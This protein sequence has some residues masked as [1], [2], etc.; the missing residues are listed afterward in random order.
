[1][2]AGIFVKNNTVELEIYATAFST[3]LTNKSGD[4]IRHSE[5]GINLW[6]RKIIPQFFGVNRLNLLPG[7]GFGLDTFDFEVGYHPVC[8]AIS[9][10][11]RSV[12]LGFLTEVYLRSNVYIDVDYRYRFWEQR[13]AD[14]DE[15]FGWLFTEYPRFDLSGHYMG[16]F[17]RKYL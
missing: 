8:H 6:Y 17:L 7:A 10:G 15:D 12:L 5:Y 16:I 9:F 13:Y 2:G 1:L 3:D 14:V 11:G 4:H